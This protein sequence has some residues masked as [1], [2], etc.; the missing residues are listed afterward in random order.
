ML[1]E[2]KI[3]AEIEAACRLLFGS[4]GQSVGLS[5]RRYLEQ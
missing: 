1:P 3:L 2:P 4:V 5:K